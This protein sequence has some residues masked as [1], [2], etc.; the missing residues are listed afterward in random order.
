LIPVEATEPQFTEPCQY[1]TSTPVRVVWTVFGAGPEVGKTLATG[2]VGEFP[3]EWVETGEERRESGER[4]MAKTN[5]PV[6][7][8][9]GADLWE[10][11]G[12]SPVPAEP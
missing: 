11:E 1:E 9:A 10:T 6:R 4:S 5:T 2:P 3:E 12:P 8:R 7:R